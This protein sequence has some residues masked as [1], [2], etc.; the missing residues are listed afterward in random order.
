[1]PECE[2]IRTV[3]VECALHRGQRLTMVEAERGRVLV[4]ASPGGVWCEPEELAVAALAMATPMARVAVAKRV[5]AGERKGNVQHPTPNAQHS[6]G[7][8]GELI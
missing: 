2:S 8:G 3:Q 5:L 1:M 4:A 6:T 7:N